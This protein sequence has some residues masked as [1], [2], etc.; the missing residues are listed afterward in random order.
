MHQLGGARNFGA[1][2]VDCHLI[3][4]LYEE[5]GLK[6]VFDH[7]KDNTNAMDEKDEQ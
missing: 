2:I 7:R 4:P 1:N 5:R 6:R 3:D